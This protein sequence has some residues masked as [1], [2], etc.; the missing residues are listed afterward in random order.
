MACLPI[1]PEQKYTHA[2]RLLDV[3]KIISDAYELSEGLRYAHDGLTN[4]AYANMA[5]GAF[6]V[7]SM[8]L[9]KAYD[10]ISETSGDY[11]KANGI[12]YPTPKTI[13]HG[14]SP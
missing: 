11:V 2:Q 9:Y 4:E 7:L 3:E 6:G 13:S 5:I 14:E 10:I 8:A 1:Q 12:N